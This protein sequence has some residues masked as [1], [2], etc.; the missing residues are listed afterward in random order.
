MSGNQNRY[1]LQPLIVAHDL[2]RFLVNTERA[3]HV[4][5][6]AVEIATNGGITSKEVRE[7]YLRNSELCKQGKITHGFNVVGYLEH[8]L[9][10]RGLP[11]GW[12]DDILLEFI[13]RGH[14]CDML[15]PGA[16]EYIETLKKLEVPQ[17][18]A[19]YGSFSG[20]LGDEGKDRERSVRWQLGKIAATP[21]LSEMPTYVLN[22]PYK[23]RY[24]AQERSMDVEELLSRDQ[25]REW[26]DMTA[27]LNLPGDN[28]RGVLL[29]SRIT[30]GD[31]SRQ[32]FTRYVFHGDDKHV[33]FATGDYELVS[34]IHV[35]PAAAENRRD[36]QQSDDDLPRGIMHA[37]GLDD[38]IPM[39]ER[40]IRDIREGES[41]WWDEGTG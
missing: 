38:A 3:L 21:E 5:G 18:I 41:S 12:D 37:V 9:E 13:K 35:V 25:L 31:D 1:N 7:A 28:S 6:E 20:E 39:I 19:T 29:S 4:V 8:T 23:S 16:H 33:A 24:W 14:Q 2:D 10:E 34:G 17:V 22:H 11:Y 32:V 30:L 15:M 26:R 36:Y 27:Q 40:R